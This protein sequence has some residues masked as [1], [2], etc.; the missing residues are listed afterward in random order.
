MTVN[1]DKVIITIAHRLQ[2]VKLLTLPA[3]T[4]PPAT[5]AA[6]ITD[7][8]DTYFAA[9]RDLDAPVSLA[10]FALYI[11]AQ[12]AGDPHTQDAPDPEPYDP[13]KDGTAEEEP[14]FTS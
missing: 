12:A 11:C 4:V 10:D 14:R 13:R 6:R 2:G 1:C 8:A 5:L 9:T 7:L 3:Y